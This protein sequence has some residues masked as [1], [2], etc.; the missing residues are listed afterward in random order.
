MALPALH[1]TSLLLSV[2]L[3]HSLSLFFS[4]LILIDGEWLPQVFPGQLGSRC[5]LFPRCHSPFCS[6]VEDTAGFSFCSAINFTHQSHPR[7]P[8]SSL[9]VSV[10]YTASISSACKCS[11]AYGKVSWLFF[12]LSFLLSTSYHSSISL[13]HWDSDSHILSSSHFFPQLLQLS[14][15]FCQNSFWFLSLSFSYSE[16]VMLSQCHVFFPI[17]AI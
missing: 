16:L 11:P 6:C 3:V 12:S 1:C 8:S 2:L 15:V 17:T 10:S 7:P 13:L 14:K 9:S 4:Y 5:E